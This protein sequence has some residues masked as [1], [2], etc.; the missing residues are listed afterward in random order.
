[1]RIFILLGILVL[2]LANK[3]DAYLDPGTGSYFIQVI[4]AISFG[5]ILTFR[6]FYTKLKER[7][8]I[9]FEKLRK[10]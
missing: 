7:V 9:L 1:M 8:I 3:S 10:K 4:L 5:F 2:I 6:A